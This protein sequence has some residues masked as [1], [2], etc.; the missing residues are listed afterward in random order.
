MAI[1][2][3]RFSEWFSEYDTPGSDRRILFLGHLWEV[4]RN[5]PNQL[6]YSYIS[7]QMATLFLLED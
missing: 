5:I 3:R 2:G 7:I 4:V 6:T 1:P